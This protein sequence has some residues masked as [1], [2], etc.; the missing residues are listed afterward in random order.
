LRTLNQSQRQT[1]SASPCAQH[2][3]FFLGQQDGRRYSHVA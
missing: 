3:T 1:S 2:R